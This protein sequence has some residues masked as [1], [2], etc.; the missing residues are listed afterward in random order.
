M[1]T[2]MITLLKKES[3]VS[4]TTAIWTY[5]IG[6]GDNFYIHPDSIE[7]QKI[8]PRYIVFCIEKKLHQKLVVLTE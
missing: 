1:L 2:K 4:N 3:I 7:E 6:D 8:R 5:N